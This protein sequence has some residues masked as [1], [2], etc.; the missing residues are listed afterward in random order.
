MAR[1]PKRL[2]T[3][4]AGAV[5]AGV[6]TAREREPEVEMRMRGSA[7]SVR[8]QFA[9]G[10]PRTP[11]A[12]EPEER[13][14]PAEI[15]KFNRAIRDSRFLVIVKRIAPR[16]WEGEP[17][18]NEVYREDCPLTLQAIQDEVFRD[19]GGRK[20]RVAVIDPST[21]ETVAARIINYDSNPII[22]SDPTEAEV[23]AMAAQAGESPDA[24][25]ADAANAVKSRNELLKAKIEGEEL[26]QDL[27][28]ARQKRGGKDDGTIHRLEINQI[29]AEFQRREDL[30]KQEHQRQLDQ[31]QKQIDALQAPR[32]GGDENAL[33]LKLMEQMKA[34]REA[35]DR[36]FE[37]MMQS[38]QNEKLAGLQRSLEEIKTQRR[39][40]SINTL[41]VITTGIEKIATAAKHLGFRRGDDD[42]EGDPDSD[43]NEDGTPKS[44]L[45]R[46]ADKYL[47]KVLSGL[48]DKEKS[49]QP[50]DKETFV[51]EMQAAAEHAAVAA[52]AQE[53]ERIL[54]MARARAAQTLPRPAASPPRPAPPP[55]AGPAPTPGQPAV[56]EVPT[57][58]APSAPPPPA[59]VVGPPPSPEP[60][61][62]AP[63]AAAPPPPVEFPVD[64]GH[65]EIDKEIRERVA[66]VITDIIREMRIR[67]REWEW[68]YNAFTELPED[69]RHKMATAQSP[70]TMID[71]FR[72]YAN[73][74]GLD[75]LKGEIAGNAK[76]S[77][78]VALGLGELAAWEKRLA[79]DPKFKPY[80][81]E[82][83]GE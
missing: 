8:R 80:G 79:E 45:E 27:E 25:R 72:G 28:V 42:D 36:R 50:V 41:D 65:A 74:G 43:F 56:I 13:E 46:M 44:L 77:D 12:E 34:D 17:C 10:A 2:K 75:Q 58:P 55:N 16:I 82:E 78:W 49:G 24:T 20:Y 59:Q 68:S 76:I 4:G 22:L 69:V 54:A 37:S 30:L 64:D 18:N 23:A 5:P 60:V 48:L 71:A 38:S 62:T 32:R 31:I 14:T 47:P 40:E 7:S 19:H 73:D 33:V 57:A 35:A 81:E 11:D 53:R 6:A 51:R 61:S 29:K 39:P 83:E 26:E 1:K 70:V 21:D 67:P 66:D 52:A 3:P 15:L 63:G 9:G